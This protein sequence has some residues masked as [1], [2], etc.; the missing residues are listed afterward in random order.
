MK[1]SNFKFQISNEKKKNEA[2]FTILELLIV[3]LVLATVGGLVVS[4]FFISLRSTNKSN[5]TALVRQNGNAAITKIAR[6]IRYAETLVGV[7]PDT[8]SLNTDPNCSNGANSPSSFPVLRVSNTNPADDTKIFTT[9]SCVDS[10]SD[11]DSTVDSIAVT[12]STGTTYVTD[13]DKTNVLTC[14]FSCI[15]KSTGVTT[16]NI[17]YTMSD[18]NSTTNA[19]IN[20]NLVNPITF[21]TSVT[22]RNTQ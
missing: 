6:Q 15:K 16:V 13:R 2:G 9:F 19:D 22:M 12:D 21:S 8:S 10:P 11:P 14:G 18:E 17:R 7:G 5:K 4:I 3:I 20:E 1:T